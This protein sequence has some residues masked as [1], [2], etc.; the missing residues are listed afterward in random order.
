[1]FEKINETQMKISETKE[2]IDEKVVS[3]DDLQTERGQIEMR[4]IND[5]ARIDEI[6]ILLGEASKMGLKTRAE[7]EII[8]KLPIEEELKP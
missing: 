1:M 2:I 8:S 6:D 4:M 5:K 3:L 7:V